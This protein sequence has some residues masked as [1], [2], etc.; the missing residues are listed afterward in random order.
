MKITAWITRSEGWWAIEIPEVYG[1][2]SQART[3]EEVEFMARDAAALLI[4]R[5]E[6]DF[7]VTIEI[8]DSEP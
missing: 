8:A 4:G 3:L 1:A 6:N 5:L 2:H 7:E